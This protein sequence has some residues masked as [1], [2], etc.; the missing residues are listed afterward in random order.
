[1]K[2]SVGITVLVLGILIAAFGWYQNEASSKTIVQI[3]K[4]EIKTE[5]NDPSTNPMLIGG[6]VVAI[7]GLV[8]VIVA[9]K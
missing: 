8:V 7:I 9:K 2:K 1:M 5:K 6:A 3:G 4:T